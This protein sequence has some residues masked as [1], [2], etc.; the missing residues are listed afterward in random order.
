MD[1]RRFEKKLRDEERKLLEELSHLKDNLDFGDDI[2]S[3]EEET[4]ETEE[5]GNMLS[6]KSSLDDRLRRVREALGRIA[7][8]TY[9]I[10]SSCAG[11]IEPEI[12]EADATST[13]CRACKAEEKQ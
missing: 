12:L 8:G 9:G 7:D 1:T 6:V 3:M 10:C 4:N 5:F 13:L 2:D 11:P